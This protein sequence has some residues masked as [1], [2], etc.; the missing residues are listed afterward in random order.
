MASS[1][2]ASTCSGRSCRLRPHPTR[3]D[4][5]V[6][7]NLISLR[8]RA[9]AT[10]SG[11]PLFRG[12][13]PSGTDRFSMLSPAGVSGSTLGTG[14]PHQLCDPVVLV[15]AADGLGGLG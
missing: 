9:G 13:S 5:Q 14:T 3:T 2:R 10:L 8:R 11:F 7:E 4:R 15:D 1:P 12:R 6:K